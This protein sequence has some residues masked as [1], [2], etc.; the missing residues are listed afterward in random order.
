M[1]KSLIIPVILTYTFI[2]AMLIYFL[3]IGNYEFIGYAAVV[4]LLFYAVIILQKKYDLPILSVWF[5]SIWVA[6]HFLGGAVYIGG[7]KLY[8]LLLI[9]IFNGSG[10][11]P[12]FI[13]LKYD[14]LVHAYCYFAFSIII[15]FILKKHMKSK[16]GPALVVFTIL[17]AIGIGLLNEII[18]FGM[19]IFADAAAAVGG[20]YN[21][22]LDLVFNLIGAIVGTG[23][24]YFVM[25]KK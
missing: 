2:L 11:S 8:D 21:T 7:T 6:S 17:S 3:S 24:A 10:I 18:E 5:F 22:A 19:V 25:E 15:Y 4:S 14:Q 23:Y 13:M 1:K 20:Y 16:Q 12:E 9:N